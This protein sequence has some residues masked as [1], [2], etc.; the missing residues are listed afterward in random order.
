MNVKRELWKPSPKSLDVWRN[1]AK[2]KYR[3]LEGAVRSSKSFVANDI[4]IHEI[5]QLPP[6]DVLISGYSITSVARNVLAEWKKTINPVGRDLFRNVKNDKDDFITI[7]WRG[8]RG[9]KFYV[10]G[11][12]KDNDFKQIQGA[13]LGYW[14][15]DEL[16]RHTESF[17]DMALTRQSPPYAK[18][19][20]TTNADSPYHFVKR[21]FIDNPELYA[22][23]EDGTSLYRRWQFQLAD[24]PSLTDDYTRSLQAMYSGVFYKRYVLGLWVVAEGSIYD[25]FEDAEPYVIKKEPGKALRHV[26]SVDYGTGAPTVFLLFGINETIRPKVWCKR[27]YYF[28]SEAS[29]RQKTDAEYS[30]DFK[31]FLGDIVPEQ[32]IYDPSA[33]SFRVQ[34][35][36]DGFFGLREADNDVVNGIRTQARMLKSGEYAILDTCE[37]TKREYPSYSWDAKKQLIGIDAPIKQNDHCLTGDTLV[38]TTYGAV[39]I[40]ELVGMVG[41]LYSMKEHTGMVAAF[42][43]VRLTQKDQ[44]I[45][46]VDLENGINLCATR[47]HKVFS[48]T[49]WKE[50][51]NLVTGEMLYVIDGLLSRDQIQQG[52]DNGILSFKQGVREQ[53]PVPAPS[54]CLRNGERE[55]TAEL[56]DT[57]FGLEQGQQQHPQSC[58]PSSGDTPQASCGQSNAGTDTRDTKDAK[59]RLPESE[60]MAL[61]TTRPTM[62]PETREAGST[63]HAD[64]RQGMPRV[65]ESVQDQ[66]KPESTVEVLPSEL[67]SNR[68]TTAVKVLRITPLDRHEDV[69]C[70]TVPQTGCFAVNGGLVVANCKDAERYFLQTMYGQDSLDLHLL[71]RM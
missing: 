20:W 13:T 14:L 23:K 61:D 59:D 26:V 62:A 49:G 67:Q 38:E 57:S 7:D 50:I 11:A 69:Y 16:T 65:R 25:F 32:I 31:E 53:S 10:R 43:N 52:Q 21:R 1:A 37:N 45:Y 51:Q 46:R 68:T 64:D 63:E 33:L 48:T 44:P 18:G 28:S 24:N 71:T 58:L 19:I 3:L 47:G 40:R 66:A 27:E 22:T 6:C 4:A 34:L 12:G 17:V 39:P 41:F 30:R 29:G 56:R 36:R 55:N 70:L 5:Q 15:A 2:A 9:K 35:E 42:R 60:S 54:L 8:L